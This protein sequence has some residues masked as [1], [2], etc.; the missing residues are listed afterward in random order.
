MSLKSIHVYLT[1]FFKWVHPLLCSWQSIFVQ[2]FTC[3]DG[4]SSWGVFESGKFV[5]KV[6]EG[7]VNFS[8]RFLCSSYFEWLSLNFTLIF[9]PISPMTVLP[10]PDSRGGRIKDLLPWGM[11]TFYFP[12]GLSCLALASL[13]W[14]QSLSQGMACSGGGGGGVCFE[15][16]DIHIQAAL[17]VF[18]W[19][20]SVFFSRI[21]ALHSTTTCGVRLH[22]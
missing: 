13:V 20:T 16:T 10:S 1:L 19:Y 8:C 18:I 12:L 9:F 6:C 2:T 22:F 14:L 3:W 5:V 4:M 21:K 7:T 11:M 17:N 15:M